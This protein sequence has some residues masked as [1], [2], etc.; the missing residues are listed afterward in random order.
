MFTGLIQK[1]GKIE[2][3]EVTPNG[4][5]LYVAVDDLW[6]D[7][8][9][10]ESIAVNG[11]CLTVVPSPL[12]HT[13]SF[14]VSDETLRK[15]AFLDSQPQQIVNLERALKVGDSLGGHFVLGH[16]DG[17]GQIIEIQKNEGSHRF[18]IEYPK[19]FQTL[20]IEKGSIAVDGISLTVCDLTD[21]SFNVYI[22]PHTIHNTHLK[23]AVSPQKVNL[24]FD[25]LGKYILRKDSK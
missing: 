12:T 5:R 7:I 16:V 18:K 8:H 25:M 2:K 21:H 23:N 10:G 17:V 22:I 19:S 3:W 11:C 14:D 6:S 1:T 15:T 9:I 20:L 24:E 13:L 4:K